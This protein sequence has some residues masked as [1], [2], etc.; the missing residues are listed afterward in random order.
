MKISQKRTCE[1]YSRMCQALSPCPRDRRQK[2]H[3]ALGYE[4]RLVN[5]GEMGATFDHYAP[6]E[7][8]PKP[9]TK[10]EL[11]RCKRKGEA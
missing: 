5:S 7:P 10:A 11:A 9:M 6:T 3:C 1:S 8:C 4:I 2:P